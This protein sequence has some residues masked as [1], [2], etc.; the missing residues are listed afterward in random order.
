MEHKITEYP[1][2]DEF[3]LLII[4]LYRRQEMGAVKTPVLE[5]EKEYLSGKPS[6]Q[7]DFKIARINTELAKRR[8]MYPG[9]KIKLSAALIDR[10]KY[11]FQPQLLNYINRF[12]EVKP[13]NGNQFKFHCPFHGD[14]TDRDPSGVIYINE[15]RWWCYGCNAGG[16]SIQAF[17][18]F[19]KLD[20]VAA[21]TRMADYVGLD[22][23]PEPLKGGF[24]IE[25]ANA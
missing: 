10:I 24:N 7:N 20:F 21:V 8:P 1:R 6:P 17:M 3:A 19:E 12:V 9:Q 2:L 25:P 13:L 4:D 16:D 15:G 18:T 23:F 22:L 11:H 14:G 5:K